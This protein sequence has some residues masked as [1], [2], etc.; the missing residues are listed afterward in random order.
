MITRL[1]CWFDRVTG[2]F[3]L[4]GGALLIQA[5]DRNVI[6]AALED[7]SDYRRDFGESCFD[8]GDKPCLDHETDE[9][10]GRTYDDLHA[11][12][13]DRP[14]R[15]AEATHAAREAR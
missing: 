7:A 14:R 11:R 9:A 10:M 6:L 1:R 4:P 13:Q 3:R 15:H 12:I 2:S 5:A 8:C